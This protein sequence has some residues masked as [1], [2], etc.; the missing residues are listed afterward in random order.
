MQRRSRAE[1]NI[2]G[3]APWFLEE[4][5]ALSRVLRCKYPRWKCPYG[6]PGDQLWVRETWSPI[7]EMRPSGYFTDPKWIGRDFFYAADHDKPTWAGSWRP[8]IHMPREASRIDLKIVQ[9]RAEPLQ[10]MNFNDAFAEGCGGDDP[11]G[12]YM[13]GLG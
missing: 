5:T 3:G 13:L 7:G 11:I 2:D 6:I 12:E 9:V 8:S 4:R 10:S 1:R